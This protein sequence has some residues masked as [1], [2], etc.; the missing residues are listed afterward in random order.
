MHLVYWRKSI[1]PFVLTLF[2]IAASIANVRSDETSPVKS[3]ADYSL[4]S[5]GTPTAKGNNGGSMGGGAQADFTQLIDLIT[6]TIAPSTWDEVGGPGS[7]SE[8]RGGVHI[9]TNSVLDYLQVNAPQLVMAKEAAREVH[10]AQNP[11]RSSH[12][13]KVSL[14]RLDRA[15]QQ[16]RSQGKP[17]PEEME[18]LAGLN[19]IQYLFIYPEEKEVV[20][21][22][23][24]DDWQ[25]SSEGKI[26]SVQS[27]RPTLHLDDLVVLLR[28]YQRHPQ[29]TFGCSIDPLPESLAKAKTFLDET[30]GKPIAQSQ[31]A[32]WLAKL[33]ESLGDQKVSIDGVS[34]DSRVAQ[35][36]ATADYHMKLV[37]MGTEKG[38]PGLKNY[39]DLIQ[40]KPGGPPPAMEA[41]RWWFTLSSRA[42]EANQDATA[43]G[44]AGIG[45]RLV[46]ENELVS[47]SGERQHTGAA[48]EANQAFTT[49]FTEN[50]AAL[51]QKYP[52]Y[53]DLRNV[54]DLAC[55]AALLVN[56]PQASLLLGELKAISSAGTYETHAVDVPKMVATVA[57]QRVVQEKYVLT[58]V[59]GGVQVS[60]GELVQTAKLR[61]DSYGKLAAERNGSPPRQKSAAIWWWD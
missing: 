36:L 31:R 6:S 58:G 37:G 61:I 5:A 15:V 45:L 12:L 57:R 35:V 11:H 26:A 29:G 60:F 52:I 46:A 34:A 32:K 49:G 44:L 13:R 3:L 22:G 28:M 4:G 55:A 56:H 2:I 1:P 16:L 17:I 7:I 48:S 25:L 24:A 8:F 19:R 47:S 30:S 9:S 39:L 38:V 43:F 23:S 10:A 27:G 21:A 53:A 14:T 42:P 20:I 33:R 51:S 54:C 18:Y 50:M 41:L 59:S 40:V